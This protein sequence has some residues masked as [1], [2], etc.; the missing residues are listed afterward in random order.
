MLKKL[1]MEIV[2][3]GVE[4]QQQAQ[5]LIGNKCDRLQGYLLSK[6]IEQDVFFERVRQ[7]GKLS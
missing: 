4:D 3:E 1:G 6:P 2:A 7:I 5:R